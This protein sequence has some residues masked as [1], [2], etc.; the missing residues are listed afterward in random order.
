MLAYLD[1]QI[2]TIDTKEKLDAII[3][4]PFEIAGEMGEGRTASTP[5]N[6]YLGEFGMIRQEYGNPYV[7]PGASARPTSRT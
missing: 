6:I 2:A 1:E 3:D 7:M 5:K 4:R